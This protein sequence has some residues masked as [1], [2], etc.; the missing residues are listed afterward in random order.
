MWYAVERCSNVLKRHRDGVVG[1]ERLVLRGD[2][3]IVVV[4][5]SVLCRSHSLEIR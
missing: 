2:S 5:A 3:Y 1:K 4:C